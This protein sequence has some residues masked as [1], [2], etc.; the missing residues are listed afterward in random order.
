METQIVAMRYVAAKDMQ[1]ILT[2]YLSDGGNLVVHEEGNILIITE[3]TDNLKRLLELV[4]ILDSDVFANERVQLYPIQNNRSKSL[5]PDLENIFAAYG[6]SRKDSAVRFISID[7]INAILA[8]SSNPGSFAEVEKWLQKL[9]QPVMNVGV[10]NYFFKIENGDA[11]NIAGV[12]LEIYG[13]SSTDGLL[14]LSPRASAAAPGTSGAPEEQKPA[15][16]IQG[17]IK[18]VPDLINNALV[19]QASP[20]DYEVIKETI[21]ELDRVPRQALIDAKIYE[22]TLSGALSLG[23]SY[24]LQQRATTPQLTT[25]SFSTSTTPPG[26]NFSTFTFIGQTRELIAFLNAQETRSRARILSSP[27]VI[28]SDNKEARIQVGSE[29]PILTSQ[30]VV[31]GGTG[32]TSLFSNTIQN[33]S[34][35]IILNVTPRI[36][37]TGLVT[38]RISQEVSVPVP[39]TAGSGIQSPSINIRSVNTELTVKDGETIAMGGIIQENKLLSK[40]RVPLLGDIPGLGLVFGTTSYTTSRTELIALI[41]PHVIQDADTAA[42]ATEDLKSKLKDLKKTLRRLD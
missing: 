14:S 33:K 23:V 39:P 7:R 4:N 16:P 15:R 17:D 2:F 27:T 10:K 1:K 22:V 8:I 3:N 21:Q 6:L 38:L 32:G 31:P 36:N 26:F 42:D 41:T 13:R 12:L 30:G 11:K 19:I 35:G 29:V 9:D 20:Q 24:F 18:I 34:T 25:A 37:S 28:A 5:I 40:N